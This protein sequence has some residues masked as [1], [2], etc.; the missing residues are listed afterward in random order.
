VLHN[1]KGAGAIIMDKLTILVSG[2]QLQCC[3]EPF[4]TGDLIEWLVA[5]WGEAM[6]GY[7]EAGVMDFYYEHHSSE[8]QELFALSGIVSSIGAMYCTFI[9]DPSKPKESKAVICSSC[10]TKPVTEAATWVKGEGKHE[11]D[12]YIVKFDD[13]TIRPAQEDEVTFA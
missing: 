13:Y 5:K 10:Y 4:K 9:P 11:F 1:A 8:Y 7:E 3:G 6:P 2:W 12:G